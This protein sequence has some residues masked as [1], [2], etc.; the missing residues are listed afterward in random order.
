M[1]IN[2]KVFIKK[3]IYIFFVFQAIFALLAS[4]SAIPQGYRLPAPRPAARPAAIPAFALSS[5]SDESDERA[6]FR[7]SARSGGCPAGQIRKVDGTCAIP[8]LSSANVYAFVAPEIEL[9]SIEV[10]DIPDPK[11]DQNVVFVRAPATVQS[12]DPIIVPAPQQKTD[13]YVL[14]EIGDVEQKV[15]EA[16]A[17]PAIEPEVHYVALKAGESIE[18]LHGVDVPTA[19]RNAKI[20]RGVQVETSDE[21]PSGPVRFGTLLDDTHEDFSDEAPISIGQLYR[22][23]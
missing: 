1:I 12:P 10:P 7:S 11:V 18:E 2:I 5:D 8:V 15:I 14:S 16:P 22:Y 6:V 9:P 21:L 23:N 4:A 19:F 13:V 20:G 17:L 3:Y